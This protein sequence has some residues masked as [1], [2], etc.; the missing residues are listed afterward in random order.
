[1]EPRGSFVRPLASFPRHS[2]LGGSGPRGGRWHHGSD[3]PPL[4]SL[5]RN[6]KVESR[7]P[8]PHHS[9]SA[10]PAKVP[11][12]RSRYIF[13][14]GYGNFRSRQLH[15]MGF[16]CE[17][18]MFVVWFGV[19]LCGL[20]WSGLIQLARVQSYHG[21]PPPNRSWSCRANMNWLLLELRPPPAKAK[22]PLANLFTPCWFVR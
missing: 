6:P 22:Y 11:F 3:R 12:L 21:E 18:A 4:S 10:R 20:V 1:M 16:P 13:A 17:F 7:L 2:T 19:F 14:T 9:S 15:P 8:Q 5:S